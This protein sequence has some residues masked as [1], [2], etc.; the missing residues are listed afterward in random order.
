MTS[1]P[2]SIIFSGMIAADPYQGGATWAALQY[3]LGLREMG[4]RVCFVE[5]LPTGSLSP[6]EIADPAASINARYFRKVVSTFGLDGAAALIMPGR[7]RQIVG[8]TYEHLQSVCARADVLLN[9]SGM[10]A[11]SALIATIPI[12][13]YLDLDPAFVQ[14]WARQGIDMRL[15]AHTHFVTVGLA[16]GSEDC[17]VP[18]CGRDWIT[19]FQPVVLNRWPLAERIRYDA[20]T[21]IGNWRG[22]GSVELNGESLGQKAHSL[23]EL[24][25]L[26]LLTD[27]RFALAMAIHHEEVRDLKALKANRWRLLDPRVVAGY[28][29][30]YGSFIRHSKGE[31]G[32]AKSGYVKSRCGWFSDRSVCYL[33]SGRPVLA[34]DTGFS[35]YLPTGRGLFPFKG[36][37]D[38]LRAIEHLNDDYAGHSR[39]ARGIAETYFAADKVLA[40]LLRQVGAIE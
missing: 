39:D 30:K 20:L 40:R 14:I 3:V 2:L 17:D 13:V 29:E 6:T 21:T 8:M 23:R 5:P 7:D 15:D 24:M 4:H 1:N 38:V 37:D 26:P 18:L 32:V 10:L 28:P 25:R 9:V 31:F 19:T 27:E 12:R 34:Q 36:E 22:Y 33:A 11:E 16:L 35:R